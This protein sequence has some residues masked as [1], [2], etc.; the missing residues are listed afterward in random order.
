M[1]EIPIPVGAQYIGQGPQIGR[2]LKR[3]AWAGQ[4]V[5]ANDAVTLYDDK[6]QMIDSAPLSA[7]ELKESK[8]FM[9][10]GF[11]LLMNGQKYSISWSRGGGGTGILGAANFALNLAQAHSPAQEFKQAYGAMGG[12][13]AQ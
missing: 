6:Q 7:V 8:S 3:F 4:V 11:Y 2:G 9:G 5:I 12:R 10:S 13:I 1:T